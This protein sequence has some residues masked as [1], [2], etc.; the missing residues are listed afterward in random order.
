[1]PAESTPTKRRYLSANVDLLSRPIVNVEAWFSTSNKM[2]PNACQMFTALE[3]E[4]L[5]QHRNQ[6]LTGS[7]S[8]CRK[9]VNFSPPFPSMSRLRLKRENSAGAK[10]NA[11]TT[12]MSGI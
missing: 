9:R 10:M 3:A 12:A 2:K 4:T 7:I 11:M 8:R 5:R 1:M 6:L